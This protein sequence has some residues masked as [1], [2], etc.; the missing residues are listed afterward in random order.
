MKKTFNYRRKIFLIFFLSIIWSTFIFCQ[1]IPY[2]AVFRENWLLLNPAVLN[3]SHLADKNK[4][5]MLNFSHRQQ[6]LGFEGGPKQS[7]SRLEN[8][9]FGKYKNMNN[10]PKFKWG[11]GFENEKL[12]AFSS[13]GFFVNY[14]YI[15]NLNLNTIVSAGINVSLGNSNYRLNSSTFLDW[16][17]DIPSQLLQNN[18]EWFGKVDFGVFIKQKLL[19]NNERINQWYAGASIVQL[20]SFEL[21][22][23][24]GTL[25][26][27]RKP[28][29]NFLAGIMI[30]NST[31]KN[32]FGNYWE[33]SIW[34]RYL[35][36]SDLNFGNIK[37]PVS[38]DFSLRYFYMNKI[39]GGAGI[40][41]SGNLMMETGYVF[42][43]ARKNR[44][45]LSPNIKSGLIC[46][47]PMLMT[48]FGF[49]IEI[50]MGINLVSY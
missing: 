7:N 44:N 12:G 26:T 6:W 15:L 13:S 9:V 47:I 17:N 20:S 45:Y 11:L 19:K 4:T 16:Q 3:H 40:G 24:N 5:L 22:K 38:T 8:L 50:F 14:A 42:Q 37:L 35:P 21:F 48:T 2:Y 1:Q 49:S 41:T 28:H 23:S 10:I 30:G 27:F 36:K 31:Y 34:I 25:N 46:N 29:F 32:G 43:N 33:P 18:A 39:W